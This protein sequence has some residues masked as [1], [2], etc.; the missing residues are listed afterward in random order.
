MEVMLQLS[1]W[2]VDSVVQQSSSPLHVIGDS[3]AHAQAAAAEQETSACVALLTARQP[4]M[5]E[6]LNS[7]G[8]LRNLLAFTTS[9]AQSFG[10][11]QVIGQGLYMPYILFQQEPFKGVP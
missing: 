6:L 9:P 2:W 11:S 1:S 10:S 5:A 3:A 4:I 7:V 8:T